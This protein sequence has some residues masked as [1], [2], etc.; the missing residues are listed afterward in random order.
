MV[1]RLGITTHKEGAKV[2]EPLSWLLQRYRD[3]LPA[4]FL[5]FCLLAPLF[6]GAGPQA[7]LFCAH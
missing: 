3:L 7:S 6:R 5:L 4:S 1:V 2:C